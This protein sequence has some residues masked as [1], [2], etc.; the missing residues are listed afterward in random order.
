MLLISGN[1]LGLYHYAPVYFSE[2]VEDVRQQNLGDDTAIINAFIDS[3]DLDQATVDEY[4]QTLQD[5]GELTKNL[6]N[7][8]Q[9]QR[10]ELL[11]ADSGSTGE[12]QAYRQVLFASGLETFF[13]NIVSIA[14][15][16]ENTPERSFIL[17]IITLLLIINAILISAIL[18]ITF[19]WTR[20]IFSPIVSLSQRL[21]KLTVERDY[22]KI[23]YRRK[24]EFSPLIQAVN[25]LSE[26]L[27]DQ[28][29]I[30]SDFVSDFSHEIKT[31][32]TALKVFLEGVEDGVV[33][34]DDKG[35]GVVHSELD[36]LLVITDSI[37]QYE[38]IEAY[39]E[40]NAAKEEFDLTEILALLREEYLPI[41]ARNSQIIS[42][43]EAPFP[44]FLER[45]LMMQLVHNIY[46]NFTKYAGPNTLLSIQHYVRARKLT[47][48]FEDDGRGV[49]KEHVKYLREKFY[50]ADSGRSGAQ[51]DRG[52]GIGVSLIEKIAKIHGGHMA[53]TSDTGKGFRLKVVME[54]EDIPSASSRKIHP[55]DLQSPRF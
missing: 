15:S 37:M 13:K 33:A 25:T 34:L 50:Q 55:Q 46:S 27:A 47:L 38:K 14:F 2:Y 49:A 45:E 6:E 30:R 41:L 39:K 1:V 11:T 20:I 10:L 18:L 40:R 42:F 31:P 44:V 32:I 28:E 22:S 8:S 19:A 51:S 24:D 21:K 54:Q 53:I 7:F 12:N 17:K 26:N 29:K 36:R 16:T 4:R 9:S 5:L 48:L 23:L 43:D 3:K 35:L 52:I